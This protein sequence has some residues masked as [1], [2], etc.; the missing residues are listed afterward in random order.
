MHFFKNSFRTSQE[1]Q[2]L[3][4][5]KNKQSLLL[6]QPYAI[7]QYIRQVKRTDLEC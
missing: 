7:Q 2:H 6:L 1:T 3:S 4:L 5:A